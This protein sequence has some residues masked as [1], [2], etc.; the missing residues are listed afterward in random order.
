M[1]PPPPPP[2]PGPPG[3]VRTRMGG[4]APPGPPSV[5]RGGPKLK[6]RL[7]R[8]FMFQVA[9]P[10]A[11]LRPTPPGLSFNTVSPFVSTPVITVYGD[12]DCTCVMMLPRSF[13]GSG[14]ARKLK[15][16]CRMSRDDGPHS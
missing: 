5:W 4:P 14:N 1:L 8:A 6:V 12:A 11:L 10:R 3:P 2:P 15:T 13:L 16:R 7:R 9:D